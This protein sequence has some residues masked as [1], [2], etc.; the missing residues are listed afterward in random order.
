MVEETVVAVDMVAV[1]AIVAINLV[2][3]SIAPGF[4]GQMKFERAVLFHRAVL[5]F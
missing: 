4:Q 2:I 5:L 1:A 3:Y